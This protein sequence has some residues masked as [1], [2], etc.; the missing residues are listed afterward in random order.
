M[1]D[2]H[3]WLSVS[4]EACCP[5]AN[6]AQQLGQK[7]FVPLGIQEQR[8]L[9]VA[10]E[11]G[12]TAEERRGCERGAQRR[13]KNRDTTL[14][15]NCLPLVDRCLKYFCTLKSKLANVYEGCLGSY[16]AVTPSGRCWRA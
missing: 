16:S 12:S 2:L 15:A 1:S 5:A 14:G 11:E 10:S 3:K 9:R 8:N 13:V 7:I 4:C 6:T